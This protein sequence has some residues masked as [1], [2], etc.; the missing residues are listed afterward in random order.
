[1]ADKKKKTGRLSFPVAIG[2]IAATAVVSIFASRVYLSGKKKEYAALEAEMPESA[3]TAYLTDVKKENYDE[4]YSEAMQIDQPFASQD[5]YAQRIKDL[6]DG[7]DPDAVSYK[8][9]SSDDNGRT[10][11]LSYD[12]K[13]LA[14]LRM[15][16]NGEG[17]WLVATVFNDNTDYIVEVP[18]GLTLMANGIQ[19]DSQYMT[20]SSTACS[21]YSG[22]Y[23]QSSAPL[24]DVYEIRNINEDASFTIADDSSCI[25]V[26]GVVTGTV[27]L[28]QDASSDNELKQEMISDAETLAGYTAADRTLGEVSA[29]SINGSDWYDRISG[30]QNYWFSE[31]TTSSFSNEDVLQIVRL[32]DNAVIADVVFDYY[33]ANDSVDRT[34]HC[35]YQMTMLNDGNGWKIAGMGIDDNMNPNYTGMETN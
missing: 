6:Y 35:G 7:I 30:M 20:V 1:M 5:Y 15:I 29:I 2:I 9:S 19:V 33:A 13:D 31:H 17:T 21:A 11:Q 3:I 24:V 28:G 23:D 18:A 27:Y 32:S 25:P 26:K 22:M 16:Q 14:Q 12:S 10:Y 34:W 4:L 8:L